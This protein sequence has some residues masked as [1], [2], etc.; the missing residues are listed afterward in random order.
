MEILLPAEKI[1]DASINEN[2]IGLR[3]VDFIDSS[4]FIDSTVIVFYITLPTKEK[5]MMCQNHSFRAFVL[6]QAI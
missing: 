2:R 3:I 6:L 1:G 4:Y 5:Q